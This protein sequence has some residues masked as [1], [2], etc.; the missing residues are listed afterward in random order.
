MDRSGSGFR[1]KEGAGVVSVRV[2]LPLRPAGPR[3]APPA[4]SLVWTPTNRAMAVR[5][6]TRGESQPS[7]RQ[8][9]DG[10]DERLMAQCTDAP[11]VSGISAIPAVQ[12]NRL[13]KQGNGFRPYFSDSFVGHSKKQVV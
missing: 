9:A 8:Q 4:V 12:S 10:V 1:N 5:P 3:L 11:I 6:G 13:A 2:R 7:G